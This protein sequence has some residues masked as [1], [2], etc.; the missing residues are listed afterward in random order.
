MSTHSTAWNPRW[1]AARRQGGA[2]ASP[3]SLCPFPSPRE[4][5]IASKD[6]CTDTRRRERCL[7]MPAPAE[8]RA[9]PVLKRAREMVEVAPTTKG[10]GRA[11]AARTCYPWKPSDL[12][13][14]R[15]S[16]LGAPKTWRRQPK[17]S[18]TTNA[19]SRLGMA[20][21]CDIA[22]VSEHGSPNTAVCTRAGS[23]HDTDTS[24]SRKSSLKLSQTLPASSHWR[25]S[26]LGYPMAR[27]GP[28]C[29]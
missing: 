4:G 16:A 5:G 3:R 17:R 12:P 19:P 29:R 14:C 6:T 23:G 21:Q 11:I 10:P 15:P 9:P 1:S 2:R 24:G 8:E 18:S 7:C 27:R 28:P 20:Q 13:V 22:A 26:G 25:K